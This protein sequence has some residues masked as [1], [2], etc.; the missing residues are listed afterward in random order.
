VC[1]CDFKEEF[2]MVVDAEK[3][4][5]VDHVTSCL[6]TIKVGAAMYDHHSLEDS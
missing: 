4:L 5:A 3:L 2:T 1:V 6:P